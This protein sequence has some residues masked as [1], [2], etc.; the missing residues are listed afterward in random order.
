LGDWVIGLSG[1]CAP[2]LRGVFDAEKFLGR[3]RLH[4]QFELESRSKKFTDQIRKIPGM[5][6]L[7]ESVQSWSG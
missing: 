1:D 2:A 5:N 4:R 3:A 7:R 6:Q